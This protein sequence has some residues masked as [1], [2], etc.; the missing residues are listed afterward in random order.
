MYIFLI[1]IISGDIC[2]LT[3][4]FNKGSM[5][6]KYYGSV[7][8]FQIF[9]KSQFWIS[10]IYISEY[11]YNHNTKNQLSTSYR[12]IINQL[13]TDYQHPP[14]I[15]ISIFSIN[16]NR[17]GKSQDQNELFVTI[18]Q[19]HLHLLCPFSYAVCIFT[20]PSLLRISYSQFQTLFTKI[21]K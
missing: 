21:E 8:S 10:D 2:S 14:N 17:S 19:N 18:H 20:L 15:I 6:L 13:Q 7:T 9:Y 4:V 3:W 12:L 5:L 11:Y 16:G 1:L